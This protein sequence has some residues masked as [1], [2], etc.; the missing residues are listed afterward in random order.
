MSLR[1]LIWPVI[2]IGLFVAL[3]SAGYLTRNLWYPRLIALTEKKQATEKE[4]ADDH[5]GHDH[6]SQDRIK[7]SPQAQATLNLDVRPVRLQKEHWRSLQVPGYVVERPGRTDQGVATTL[8]GIVTEVVAVPGEAVEPGQKLFTIRVISEHLQAS[9]RELYQ[10]TREQE[11]NREEKARLKEIAGAIPEIELLKLDYALRRLKAKEMSY[12][13]ELGA[14][15]LTPEQIE[16]IVKGTFIREITIRAPWTAAS[17]KET[18]TLVKNE[19]LVPVPRAEKKLLLSVEALRVHRGDQVE[20]GQTLA[21]LSEHQVLY[22]EGQVFRH[23]LPLVQRAMK[24]QWTVGMRLPE[25]EKSI[26]PSLPESLKILFQGDQV[27]PDS[28]TVPVYVRLPNQSRE[29][30]ENGKRFRVWR[31]LPSQRAFLEI[32]VEKFENV[33]VLPAKA[34][35]QEGAEHYVFQQNGSAFDR[36]EVQVLYRDRRNVVIA[37][38]GALIEK[39]SFVAHTGAAQLQRALAIQSSSGV[40]DP[41]AG[42]VH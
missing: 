34:V 21:V 18:I 7:L 38:D 8:P 35:V 3:G 24:E 16:G 2:G 37:N 13:Y 5:A 12:R 30:T 40:I 1:K 15:G 22:L 41:H 39:L 11:I 17:E 6:G 10:I 28:Q 19:V 33:F 32:P 31:F 4:E 27:D 26:W 42:H 9:Q 36:K 20:A 23:E 25:Q 14:R 29:R